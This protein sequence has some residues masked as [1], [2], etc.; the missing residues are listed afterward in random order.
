MR[1]LLHPCLLNGRK[2]DPALYIETL[3]EKHAVLFDLGD[4]SN[5]PPRKIHRLEHVFVSHTHIDHFI[6]FDRVLRVL[7]G[8]QK[9]LNFMDRQTSSNRYSTSFLRIS[10][11]SLIGML[12]ISS[13]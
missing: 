9:T 4:L 2:G 7:A 13:L 5:L 11:I 8:R 6:G 3:F 12:S 10:G 1:P